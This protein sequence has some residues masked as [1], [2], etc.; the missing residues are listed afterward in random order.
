[1]E[2]MTLRA[3]RRGAAIVGLW[4][5]AVSLAA[6]YLL[7]GLVYLPLLAWLAAALSVTA[8][9]EYFSSVHVRVGAHHLTMRRGRVLTTVRRV[10]LR[11][12]AGCSIWASPLQRMT[13]TCILLIHTSGSTT[14]LPG[15]RRSDAEQLAAYLAQGGVPR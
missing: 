3:T 2:V 13:G 6:A 5:L 4:S 11:F 15:I 1:M 10:P 12:V 7:R 14:F 9:P 8:V